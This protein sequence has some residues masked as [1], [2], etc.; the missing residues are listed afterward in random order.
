MGQCIERLPHDACGSSDALQT[1]EDDKGVYSG[2]C[3]N[4]DTYVHDPYG[5]GHTPAKKPVKSEEK[6]AQEMA[7]MGRCPAVNLPDR[8][9]NKS[10]LE[11][12][13]VTVGLSEQD[14]RTPTFH[15]Y[16]YEKDGEVVAYKVRLVAEKHFWSVGKLKEAELFGW[17]QALGTG[18]KALYIT[19]GECDAMALFQALKKKSKGTLY[20]E[21]NP[22]II[23]LISGAGSAKKDLTR[24]LPLI[25]ANF[26]E[27]VLVLDQ[28]EAGQSRIAEVMQLIPYATSVTLPAKDPNQCLIDG[29]ELALCNAVLFKRTKA[30]NTRLIW[31]GDLIDEARKETPM[32]LSWPWERLT[33]LTRGIR[34]GETIYLGAGV[35]MGKTTM[36]DT[37]IGHMITE[38]NLKVFCAQPEEIATQTVKHIVGKVAKRIFHDPNIPFDYAAYDLAAPKVAKELL[39]L[40]LY[41]DLSWET[42]RGDIMAATAEG[43]RVVFIDPITN[44]TNGV[45]SGEAN[46]VLQEFAQEIAML[47]KDLN[48]IIF[49]FCHLKA[50]VTGPP[51]ERGGSVFSSQF[52]GS[53]AMMRSCHLMLGLEGDKDPDLPE[54]ERN[55]RRLVILEDRNLGASGYVSL[56]YDQH[57]GLCHELPQE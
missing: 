33:E 23:S 34:W 32:G 46:V 28:D 31:A 15:Y 3:F 50:P 11:Y 9:L 42:L 8:R 53:R 12:F 52:A 21:H 19:E 48:I 18:A 39:C 20:E 7:E 25:T 41:Q 38:H 17:H 35:K 45:S 27:V 49:L 6:I 2:W 26:K 1:F 29:H 44:L 13:G 22:A 14:G 54:E 43:C 40:D 4:C 37:L 10:T 5:E 24:Y 36:V 55:M 16:P 57:T 30:K 51:H 56:Y 47:A